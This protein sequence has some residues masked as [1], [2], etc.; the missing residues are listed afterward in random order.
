MKLDVFCTGLG[1]GRVVRNMG[2][3]AEGLRDLVLAKRP[4]LKENQ[5]FSAKVHLLEAGNVCIYEALE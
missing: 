5:S 1:K 4:V 2:G 3:G